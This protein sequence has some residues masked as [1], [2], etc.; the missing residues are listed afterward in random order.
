MIAGIKE[1]S[2]GLA[3]GANDKEKN[4]VLK[5]LAILQQSKKTLETTAA[6]QTGEAK[7]QIL[8]KV[9]ILEAEYTNFLQG[10]YHLI[11]QILSFYWYK[12]KHNLQ[13]KNENCYR[14]IFDPGIEMAYY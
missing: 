14:P 1:F 12:T 5:N 11:F 4:E 8:K 13:L 10:Q 9:E 6:K 7:E 2:G 3:E